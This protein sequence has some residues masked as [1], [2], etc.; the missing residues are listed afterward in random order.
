ML[1]GERW[2]RTGDLGLYWPD[3]TLEFLG[4]V[5]QQLKIGGY[6]IEPGEIE[7][8][9]KAHLLVSDAVVV[10]A[11]KPASKLVAFVVLKDGSCEPMS[12]KAFLAEHVPAYM[13]PEHVIPLKELP[14][15]W[16]GK[17]DRGKLVQA[18]NNQLLVQAS[19]PASSH[20][21]KSLA[22]LW[23]ELLQRQDVG[24][25]QSFFA[26]GGNSLLATQMI[27]AIRRQF[28]IVMSLK[29]L[30]AAPTVAT[31]AAVIETETKRFEDGTEE[32]VI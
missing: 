30:L 21:E 32:G 17:I 9:L 26:L 22:S 5:D 10:A 20:M 2:Y 29:Q 18:A 15:T 25:N 19:E 16:N 3:G 28:G 24:R 23:A 11:Q 14:L 8:C 12:L 1:E 27:E 31:L 4:R 13:V 7:A 6:R